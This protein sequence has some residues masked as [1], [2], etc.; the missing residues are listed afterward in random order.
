MTARSVLDAGRA[1]H[2]QL[3]LDQCEI[4]RPVAPVWDP[5]TG[6]YQQLDPAVIYTGPCRVKPAG[7]GQETQAGEEQ[8]AVRRYEV[9]LP[10]DASG[11]VGVGDVLTVTDSTD[12]WLPQRPLVVDH[13]EVSTARTA[14]WLTVVDQEQ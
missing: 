3:M 11:P 13:P 4:A 14:R 6:T 2:Q 9:A 5:E 10:A 1:A 8:L 7:V 12:A